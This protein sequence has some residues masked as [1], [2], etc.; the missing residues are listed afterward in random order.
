MPCG[1]SRERRIGRFGAGAMLGFAVC[2]SQSHECS[3]VGLSREAM[4]A[5]SVSLPSDI[6]LE[7]AEVVAPRT[8]TGPSC[9]IGEHAHC[10]RQS[11]HLAVGGPRRALQAMGTMGSG[12]QPTIRDRRRF[13]FVEAAQTAGLP[14]LSTDL[15]VG[16]P[17]HQRQRTRN[18]PSSAKPGPSRAI[19]LEPLHHPTAL[20]PM[21]A[22]SWT[23]QPARLT[24][25]LQ[26][27]AE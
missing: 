11:R 12:W 2:R 4:A 16:D 6:S 23:A 15:T 1:A 14:G 5:K 20:C 7:A 18:G 13:Y 24:R 8:P 19:P 9:T 27:R 22:L 21:G 26:T 10:R 17:M 3:V 25:A